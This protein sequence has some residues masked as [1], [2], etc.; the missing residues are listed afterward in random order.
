MVESNWFEGV[1]L[2]AVYMILGLAFY[3]VPGKSPN[4]S[5]EVSVRCA[6]SKFSIT[7]RYSGLQTAARRRESRVSLRGIGFVLMTTEIGKGQSCPLGATP[8]PDGVNFSVFSKSCEAMELLLFDKV[9]DP[10]P[11]EV[12]RLDSRQNKTHHYWHIFVGGMKPGQIYGYRALG[13]FKPG[14]RAS[15]RLRQSAAGSLR[16]RVAVP[17]SYSRAAACRRGDNTAFAMKSVVA[18]LG[19]IRLGRRRSS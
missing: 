13:P 4:L 15:F 17:A 14:Q 3:F 12:I 7:I 5:A 10:R 19:R 9:E 2:L 16:P 6:T 8:S 18:D 1:L 11:A